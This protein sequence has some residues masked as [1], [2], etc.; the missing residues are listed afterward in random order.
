[1]VAPMILL[2]VGI[3]AVGVWPSLVN[4]LSYNAAASLMYPF[5]L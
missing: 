4:F 5:G 1:M 2:A 3:V